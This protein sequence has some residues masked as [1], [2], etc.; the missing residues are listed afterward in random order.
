[1]RHH[2]LTALAA[3]GLGAPLAAHA[4]PVDHAAEAAAAATAA[5]EAIAADMTPFDASRNAQ[6]DVDAAL[7]SAQASGKHV[8]LIM[9]GS[10]CHDSMALWDLFHTPRTATMLDARYETVWVDVG[11]RDRNLDI[12]RRFGLDGLHGTPTV[13]IIGPNGIATNLEDAP[14]WRNAASRKPDAIHRHFSRAVAPR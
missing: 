11:H 14:T 12:A 3:L 8:L 4:Q 13:L 7:A 6:A 5:A 1:V 10:W 9:G 2:A